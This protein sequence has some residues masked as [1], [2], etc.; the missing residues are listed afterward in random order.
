MVGGLDRYL[1]SG[2]Y[3]TTDRT[4]L[5]VNISNNI[6]TANLQVKGHASDPTTLL[7][8]DGSNNSLLLLDNVGNLHVTGR[9]TTENFTMLSGATADYVL[10]SDASGNARWAPTSGSI[11]GNTSGD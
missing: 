7:V 6:P 11:T 10:T 5:G 8:Q 3:N 4:K 9:T 1:L 2:D